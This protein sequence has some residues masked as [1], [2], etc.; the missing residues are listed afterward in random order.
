MG[1]GVDGETADVEVGQGAQPFIVGIGMEPCIDG[2]GIGEKGVDGEA[3]QG[4]CVSGAARGGEDEVAAGEGIL[5][6]RVGGK[7]AG[8]GEED[9][10][11]VRVPWDGVGSVP[12]CGDEDRGG[13]DERLPRDSCEQ[14]AEAES[15]S[16]GR[17]E[18]RTV[19][20]DGFGEIVW[21]EERVGDEAEK[22]ARM[23]LSIISS[24]A[25]RLQRPVCQKATGT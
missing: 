24:G 12:V 17:Q 9:A 25:P 10:R 20:T 3:D 2:G 21:F 11:S 6:R 15:R 4:G 1:A 13:A 16:V 7:V 8:I 14:R 5:G 22:I 23:V 19:G 18:L